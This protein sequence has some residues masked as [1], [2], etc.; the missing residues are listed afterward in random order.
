MMAHERQHEAFE[1]PGFVAYCCGKAMLSRRD[2]G[3]VRFRCANPSHGRGFSMAI[4]PAEQS[5]CSC[6]SGSSPMPCKDFGDF[7]LY[8]GCRQCNSR[9]SVF[10]EGAHVVFEVQGSN[11]KEV[12]EVSSEGLAKLWDHLGGS[13]AGSPQPLAGNTLAE[14]IKSVRPDIT[15]GVKITRSQ[16]ITG[17]SNIT[18]STVQKQ[19]SPRSSVVAALIIGIIA[20]LIAAIL[21]EYFG[22][23]DLNEQPRR[24][25]RGIEHPSL[26]SFRGKPRGIE[27]GGIKRVP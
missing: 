7:R 4:D 18:D 10:K 2:G 3:H 26:N 9:Y 21:L 14:I 13:R 27:P 19:A 20:S 1:V 15:L 8:A 25:Q 11:H 6:A 24:K 23:T 12:E 22:V 17:D 5:F 16:S